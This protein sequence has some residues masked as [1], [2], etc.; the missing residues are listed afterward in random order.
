LGRIV[1]VGP[2]Q[3]NIAIDSTA[4]NCYFELHP[5]SGKSSRFVSEDVLDLS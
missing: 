5:V 1:G 4:N 3:S 2:Y